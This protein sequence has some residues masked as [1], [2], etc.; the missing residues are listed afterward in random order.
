MIFKKFVLKIKKKR[1]RR[2]TNKHKELKGFLGR[3]RATLNPFIMSVV[4]SLYVMELKALEEV[5]PPRLVFD[6]AFIN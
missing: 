5:L 1:G 2:A 4:L 3:N 6:V